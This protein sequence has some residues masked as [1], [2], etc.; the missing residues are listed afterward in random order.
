MSEGDARCQV[1]G[2]QVPFRHTSEAP[3]P[4]R[5]AIGW[6]EPLGASVKP[7]IVTGT[8]VP[9]LPAAARAASVG[10]LPPASPKSGLPNWDRMSMSWRRALRTGSTRAASWHWYTT[11]N[12]VMPPSTASSSTMSAVSRPV[13]GRD[14]GEFSTL[15]ASAGRLGTVPPGAGWPVRGQTGGAPDAAGPDAHAGAGV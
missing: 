1:P 7:L 10:G 9:A 13:D 8:G 11:M 5:V 15:M 3:D 6:W 12:L 4:T 14:S 2:T